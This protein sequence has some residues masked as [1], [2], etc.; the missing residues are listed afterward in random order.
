MYRVETKNV[1]SVGVLS[2]MQIDALS[3]LPSLDT[4]QS[5][6]Q[7]V[8]T[9]EHEDKVMTNADGKGS[10][11]HKNMLILMASSWLD[12]CVRKR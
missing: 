3:S 8:D 12:I 7:L 6:L 9:K 1:N 5:L 4:V 2:T 10:Q 11:A